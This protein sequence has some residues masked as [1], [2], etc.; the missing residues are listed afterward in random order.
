VRRALPAVLLAAGLAAPA[1][2]QLA[3][4]VSADLGAGSVRTVVTDSAGGSGRLSGAA[5]LGSV[6]VRWGRVAIGGYY[7][8]GQV[9]PDTGSGDP[10]DVVEA[11]GGLT[12]QPL[13]WLAVGGGVQARAYIMPAGTQRW[14]L[15]VVRARAEGMLLVP[16]LRTHAELWRALSTDV[17]V[18]PGGGSAMGGE[19]GL[20]VRLAQA[21]FWG[22]LV[23]SIDRAEVSGGSRAET[24]ERLSFSVGYGGP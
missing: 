8:Q 11:G 5:A 3:R 17:N 21:P 18:G 20:T 16:V 15:G 19:A 12:V 1:R 9:S 14:V 2:A 24:F 7:L 22:R 23:Y 13:A 4:T 6:S 10:R